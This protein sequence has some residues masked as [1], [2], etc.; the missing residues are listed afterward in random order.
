MGDAFHYRIEIEMLLN[1]HP[2]E[3][4]VILWTVAYLSS[5]LFKLSLAIHSIDCHDASGRSAFI[6]EALEGGGFA[7]AVNSKHRKALAVVQSKRG[8]LNCNNWLPYYAWVNL[9]EVFDPDSN[10]NGITRCYP[11]LFFLHVL[12]AKLYLGT[13]LNLILR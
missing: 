8:L 1:R 13:R 4:T 9:S 12:I 11:L 10:L 2:L 5:H 6:S 3:Y 7:R